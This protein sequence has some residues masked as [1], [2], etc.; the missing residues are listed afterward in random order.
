MAEGR[1][2]ESNVASLVRAGLC[3]LLLVTILRHAWICDDAYITFRSADQLVHG[4]GPVFNAGERVQVF[5]HPLWMLA[6]AAANWLLGGTY[7]L[8]IVLGIGLSLA[9]AWLLAWRLAPTPAAGALALAAL[10][11]SVAFCDYATSGLENPL[12]FVLLGAFLLLYWEDQPRL[13]RLSLVACLLALNR[14]DLGLLVGPAVVHAAWTQ[15]RIRPVL[16]GFAPLV[17][18]EL[19]SLL[20][21]GFLFPNTAYA[22]LGGSVPTDAL[23]EQGLL[24]LV[25]TL[26]LDPMS[27]LA[28][29]AGLSLPFVARRTRELAIVA[30]TFLYLYYVAKIG[31]DFMAGRFIAVPVY[32]ATAL[33]VRVP[34]AGGAALVPAALTLVVG[35]L[36]PNASIVADG[37]YP[38]NRERPLRDVRWVTDERGYYQEH[39]GLLS[40]DR[41]TDMPLK[42]PYA[43]EGQTMRDS[44]YRAFVVGAVGMRAFYAGRHKYVTDFL[45]IADPLMARLPARYQER[46]YTGHW[47]RYMPDGYQYSLETG[48]NHILDPAVRAYY[49]DLRLA[50]R[51]PL[52]GGARLAAV[53]RLNA[54]PLGGRIDFATYYEPEVKEEKLTKRTKTEL[55]RALAVLDVDLEGFRREA[56][57][58]IVADGPYG[59]VFVLQHREVGVMRVEPGRELVDV[60]ADASRRGYDHIRL[61]ALDGPRTFETVALAK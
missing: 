52:L 22:K 55:S 39:T 40:A 20:Y 14:L 48:E 2:A 29:L 58:Q 59:L 42:Q 56:R 10:V 36:V 37:T 15:R 13:G 43:K 21:Y 38:K 51:G 12:S 60:P 17:A 44:P 9:G 19:F 57:L 7:W 4:N 5:T 1:A 33:L 41:V 24:Y 16:V 61:V 8:A 11:S 53:W 3:V 30:G 47:D 46:W 28:I 34:L 18:W 25:T 31:G 35:A 26:D 32:V 49:D 23:F 54:R 45:G 6:F 50:L 27:A